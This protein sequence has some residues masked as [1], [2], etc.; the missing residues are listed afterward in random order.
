MSPVTSRFCEFSDEPI[1][2]VPQ[3]SDEM[4]LRKY[5]NIKLYKYTVFATV[6]F[7]LQIVDTSMANGKISGDGARKIAT[8]GLG[9]SLPKRKKRRMVQNITFVCIIFA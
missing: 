7:P 5:V 4:V 6:N 1:L 8:T 9:K 3:S 2:G